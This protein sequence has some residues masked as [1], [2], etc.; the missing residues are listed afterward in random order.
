M[1]NQIYLSQFCRSSFS[2]KLLFEVKEIDVK[3]IKTLKSTFTLMF[4][5]YP[6]I[7]SYTVT[8]YKIYHPYGICEK[9]I[10]VVFGLILLLHPM[11]DKTS[12]KNALHF[13]F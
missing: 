5:V 7:P 6:S 9:I 4:S 13:T 3:P 12:L 1:K 11:T 10:Q 8:K 2:Y